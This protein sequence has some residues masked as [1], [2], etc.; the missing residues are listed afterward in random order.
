VREGEV[1]PEDGRIGI[2]IHRW[3]RSSSNLGRSAGLSLR[4]CRIRSLHSGKKNK[5][6]LWVMAG[7]KYVPTVQRYAWWI[8]QITPAYFLHA[9]PLL[10]FC[11]PWEPWSRP[12]ISGSLW[13]GIVEALP[14]SRLSTHSKVDK[15]ALLFPSFIHSFRFLLCIRDG[16]WYDRMLSACSYCY[17]IALPYI[18]ALYPHKLTSSSYAAVTRTSASPSR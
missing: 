4:H 8:S 14:L 16:L 17:N 15:N 18:I 13:I 3:L 9:Q 12:L 1:S 6:G 11:I 2:V 10:L 5:V 7:N